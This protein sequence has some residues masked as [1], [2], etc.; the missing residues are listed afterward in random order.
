MKS[1]A[2]R[3]GVA[4]VALT[5]GLAAEGPSVTRA[6]DRPELTPFFG[7]TKSEFDARKRGLPPPA[8]QPD[9][10]S[11]TFAADASGHFLVEPTVNGTRVRMLV[12]TGASSIVLTPED[13]RRLGFR[14]STG[15]FTSKTVTA[16]GIVLVAPVLL[17]EVAI[18]EISVPNVQAVVHSENRL[19]ISL[20]GMSFLSKLTHFEVSHGK[21]VLRR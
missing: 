1:S 15:D 14:P 19:P 10:Y 20:L 8:A 16:N 21:L 11:V 5:L 4:L 13:A 3:L 12:D 6:Q 2:L 9:P 7:E 17:R 18:G